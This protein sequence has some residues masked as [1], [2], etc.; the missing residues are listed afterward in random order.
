MMVV[1]CY[2]C[3]L[4]Q[5]CSSNVLGSVVVVQAKFDVDSSI[6]TKGEKDVDMLYGFNGVC[7]CVRV[8]MRACVRACVC[9]Y[10][11]V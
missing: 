5:G 2:K 10:E 9:L 6:A 11:C 3:I 7:A 8:C 4:L 1:F